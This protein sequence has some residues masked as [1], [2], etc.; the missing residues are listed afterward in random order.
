MNR[1]LTGARIERN[2][3][4]PPIAAGGTGDGCSR[5][6]A[7]GHNCKGAT[8][9]ASI[10]VSS[11]NLS[12]NRVT[13][14]A[15]LQGTAAIGALALPGA[16]VAIE[17]AGTAPPW[18]EIEVGIEA[19]YRKGS[20]AYSGATIRRCSNRRLTLLARGRASDR[21]EY[22]RRDRAVRGDEQLGQSERGPWCHGCAGGRCSANILRSVERYLAG[23][24]MA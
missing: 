10:N 12:R 9:M 22:R 16:P 3:S 18:I 2:L 21:L 13:R 20:T 5:Q 1:T 11:D 24:A 7:P 15:A 23:R 17:K 8:V 6:P 4:V 14:R 19:N